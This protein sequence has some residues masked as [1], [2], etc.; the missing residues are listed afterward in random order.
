V[1]IRIVSN[2]ADR[3]PDRD[4]L[5]QLAAGR[6]E[7]F[8]E[9]YDHFGPR[10]YRTAVRLL[11]A[12]EDAEDAVQELFMALLRSRRGLGDVRDLTAY[13]FTSLRRLAGRVARRRAAAP[14][15]DSR[16]VEQAPATDKASGEHPL[17]ECLQQALR[18]LPV[19]Q[20]E[21]VA[22]KIDGELTFAEIA[23]VLGISPNTAAS[24]YRYAFQKLREAV[25]PG[26]R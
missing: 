13:M 19:E 23:D 14:S 11:G 25:S 12:R 16:R 10:L 22:L 8:A 18:A 20:R 1:L 9:L 17:Q 24:R 3:P 6:V 15:A 2:P 21:V 4:L 26:V 7:A 5:D